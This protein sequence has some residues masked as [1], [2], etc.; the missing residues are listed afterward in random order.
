MTNLINDNYSFNYAELAGIELIH[1][2]TEYDDMI[3]NAK[4][5]RLAADDNTKTFDMYV[6]LAE[7]KY[8][9]DRGQELARNKADMLNKRKQQLNR[10]IAQIEKTDAPVSPVGTPSE[11]TQRKKQWKEEQIRKAQKSC[12]E[13][14]KE[15]TEHYDLLIAQCHQQ[16]EEA[17]H[18]FE[19]SKNQRGQTKLQ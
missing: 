17:D 2:Q 1:N 13:D 12:E 7:S 16:K 18:K 19:Q 10:E 11:V 14:S 4:L 3:I 8:F 5:A 6:Y 15:I 9:L